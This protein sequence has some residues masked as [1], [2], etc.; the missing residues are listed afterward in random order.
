MLR[1]YAPTTFATAWAKRCIPSSISASSTTSDGAKRITSG[2]AFST[3]ARIQEITR[4]TFVLWFQLCANQQPHTANIAKY[5]V[6]LIDL[7]QMV[8]KTL[9]FRLN[10]FQHFRGIDDIKRRP[11]YCTGQNQ[12]ETQK[13]FPPWS[14]WR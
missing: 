14:A 7:L 8:N 9:A 10:A 5:I 4:P 3:C 6:L 1:I 2:P 13:Q 12:D 11:R